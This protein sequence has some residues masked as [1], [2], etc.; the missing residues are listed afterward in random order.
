MADCAGAAAECARARALERALAGQGEEGAGGPEGRLERARAHALFY[1]LGVPG[2]DALPAASLELVQRRAPVAGEGEAG[3]K[4]E[5]SSPAGGG[6]GDAEDGVDA[7]DAENPAVLRRM[8]GLLRLGG[9]APAAQ[10]GGEVGGGTAAAHAGGEVA[11]T[12]NPL[13]AARGAG[14]GAGAG[15][16]FAAFDAPVP[17]LSSYDAEGLSLRPRV[18]GPLEGVAEEGEEEE[19]VGTGAGAGAAPAGMPAVTQ[20]VARKDGEDVYYVCL[21]G[22]LPSAWE[23]PPGGVLVQE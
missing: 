11:A 16:A 10:G 12:A 14:A 6:G 3:S 19:A 18:G 7:Y 1:G 13:F 8:A 20:W 17:A 15:S 22:W 21:G 2:G 5:E 4:K 23:V 9:R